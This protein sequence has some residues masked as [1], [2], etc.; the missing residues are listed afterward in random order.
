MLKG[1][2]DKGKISLKIIS[3]NKLL[4]E[5]KTNFEQINCEL[6]KLQYLDSK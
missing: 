1:A 4:N 6:L 2:R 5:N 3:I